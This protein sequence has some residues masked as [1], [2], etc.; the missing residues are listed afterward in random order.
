MNNEMICPRH[1]K[2]LRADG[3]CPECIV[4]GHGPKIHSSQVQARWLN[5]VWPAR[6]A[7]AF[8]G[9]AIAWLCTPLRLASRFANREMRTSSKPIKL[10][11]QKQGIE[12]RQNDSVQTSPT[13]EATVQVT[14]V[15][16]RQR[17]VTEVEIVSMEVRLKETK[18]KKT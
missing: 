13:Q 11:E 2:T 15:A 4:K 12:V 1:N 17:L 5:A 16:V 8:I 6:A 9:A 14:T 10:P 7:V 18:G 3:R